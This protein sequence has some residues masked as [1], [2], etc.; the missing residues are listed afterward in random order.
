M[1]LKIVG[2]SALPKF[3]RAAAC[4]ASR[5]G[6]PPSTPRSRRRACPARVCAASTSGMPT[7]SWRWPC[8]RYSRPSGASARAREV[9]EPDG[10]D[11]TGPSS[12]RGAVGVTPSPARRAR[13]A[14]SCAVPAKRP[15]SIE[16]IDT[17]W[18]G[19]LGAQRADRALLARPVRERIEPVPAHRVLVRDLVQLGVG[20]VVLR[21]HVASSSGAVGHDE[22]ECG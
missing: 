2:T 20:H 6:S 8:S 15:L 3:E 22:S 5:A 12:R 13:P 21:G 17:S 11:R 4:G 9:G 19:D 18:P 16:W 7:R 14:T 10:R 1:F